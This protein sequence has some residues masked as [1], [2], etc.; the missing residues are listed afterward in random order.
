MSSPSNMQ[1]DK[2]VYQST[3]TKKTG[4]RPRSK[5][6]KNAGDSTEATAKQGKPSAFTDAEQDK[7]IT[8]RQALYYE[9]LK[10]KHESGIARV[11][12][13]K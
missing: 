13:G 11:A 3:S 10:A 6:K 12:K 8:E 7:Y 9:D 4:S 1:S 2:T 5:G